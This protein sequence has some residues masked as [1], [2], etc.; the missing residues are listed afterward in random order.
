[1]SSNVSLTGLVLAAALGSSGCS[2]RWEADETQCS[3]PFI[4]DLIASPDEVYTSDSVVIST[5]LYNTCASVPVLTFPDYDPSVASSLP[6]YEI[7]PYGLDVEGIVLERIDD[8]KLVYATDA[9]P[10][11]SFT[12]GYLRYSVTVYGGFSL[13]DNKDTLGSSITLLAADTGE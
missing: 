3:D 10:L 9:L 8:E 11:A 5:Y 4:Y 2:A 1:M 13:L 7:E 6:G 12:P